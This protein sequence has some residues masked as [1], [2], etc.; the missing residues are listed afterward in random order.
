M[1]VIVKKLEDTAIMPT[2][3]HETSDSFYIYSLDQIT[4]HD[5]QIRPVRTGLSFTIPSGYYIEIIQYPVLSQMTKLR[6]IEPVL[7]WES[8]RSG[9]LVI[10]IENYDKMGKDYLIKKGQKIAQGRLR[11]IEPLELEL[12]K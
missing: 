9:E 7:Y 10:H 6:Q 11:K 5:A 2:F 12:W 1:K 4:I 8:W 3:T